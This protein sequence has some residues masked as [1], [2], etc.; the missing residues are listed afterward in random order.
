M[1]CIKTHKK[2]ENV[3]QKNEEFFESQP[4][5]FKP[6]MDHVRPFFEKQDEIAIGHL[7]AR[8]IATNLEP[9]VRIGYQIGHLDEFDPYKAIDPEAYSTTWGVNSPDSF[10]GELARLVD[11]LKVEWGKI[12]NF[13][14]WVV[15][16]GSNKVRNIFGDEINRQDEI[17][18]KEALS[19][20]LFD[21]KGTYIYRLRFYPTPEAV[22]NLVLM[23]GS[24]ENKGYQKIHAN[25]SLLFLKNKSNWPQVLDKAIEVYPNLKNL[26]LVLENW[27]DNEE[28]V[29]FYNI[30]PEIKSVISQ[31]ALSMYEG[32]KSEDKDDER[33]SNIKSRIR[34]LSL[35]CLDNEVLLNF[36][37][38][39]NLL[40]ESDVSV[41]QQAENILVEY[42]KDNTPEDI[43]KYRYISRF[44]RSLNRMLLGLATKTN[45]EFNDYK[46]S[47]KK[48]SEIIVENKNDLNAITYL[49]SEEIVDKLKKLDQK[50]IEFFLK[51]Y[52]QCPVLYSNKEFRKEFC[53]FFENTD[54]RLI[55]AFPQHATALMDEKMRETRSFI[56]KNGDLLLKNVSDI[57]FM[58]TFVGEF[59][60]K[61]DQLIRGY[62]DCLTEGSISNADKELVIEFARQF[63]V[64]SPII[65]KSYKEAKE[66]GH[67]KVYIAQLQSLAEKMTGS[68]LVTDEERKKQYYRELLKHVYP[69][70]SGKWTTYESNDSCKDR[71][72]DLTDF[73]IEPRYEIDL[74]SQNEIR[75][76][77]GETLDET[78]KE[79]LQEPILGVAKK[80]GVLGHDKEKIQ[81]VLQ[82]DINKKFQEIV[83]KNGL[84][85]LDSKSITKIEEKLFLIL[86]DSIYG[87][88]LVDRDEI[89]NLM[90]TYEFT[91][92]EDI[93][94]YIAGTSDRV[95]RANN[96]D[97]ALFC[98]LESF[99]S[100]RIKEV[101]RRL[102]QVAWDNPEIANI[103]PTFFKKL[104]QNTTIDQ[105]KDMINKLQIHRLGDSEDFVKKLGKTLEK[106]R[107]KKYATDEIRKI[108]ERYEGLTGG[109][110]EKA[111]SSPKSETRAFYGQLRSQR[112]RTFEA[113]KSITGQE[114]DPNETHLGEINF[115]QALDAE[116][117][118]KEGKYDEEQ[119]ASYTVQR[120]IDL[121]EDE[122]D[123]I[124]KELAKFESLSG[125]QRE[126]LYSYITKSNESA[127]ARMVG[128]VCVAGDN[129]GSY[130]KENMWDMPNYF[131]MVFQ[132]PETLQCQGLALLHY[133]K[134][135]DNKILTATFDPSSTYLYSVDEVAL[136][137]GI[138]KS[139]ERFAIEN[140][141]DMIVSSSDKTIRT[142][143]TG[144]EFE[145]AIE[146][147][148]A[149]IGQKFNFGTTRQFSYHPNY[150]VQEMDVIWKRN[151]T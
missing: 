150:Q 86:A 17:Y 142:N 30:N 144:G 95:G 124:D 132:E 60:N 98:E 41:F 125:K 71:N 34:E 104:A 11:D 87:N 136:F 37:K 65:I 55:L 43:E 105:R 5:I 148:V 39:K 68:G 72:S 126:V 103:M 111:S 84:Y 33:T 93:S 63:R 29:N 134:E 56:F 52:Q 36:L 64:I 20:S 6:L 16:R 46:N 35:N 12:D 102:I 145:K 79:N 119:F 94:D 32:S 89:K 90:I 112:E 10:T 75:V 115:Q 38:E 123:R 141:F 80:M 19:Y 53:Q 128:G 47:L 83:E 97:Y 57:K 108:I 15:L 14:F 140:D 133:F 138:I 21:E 74:L 31:F 23:A 147:R 70:N 18:Y 82:E 61:S 4:E 81:T 62:K 1:N 45:E 130:P 113:L 40:S 100:D 114:V 135:G 109:L 27:G 137:N 22:R 107:G 58:N 118:I 7:F 91:T 116:A 48:L 50:D 122:R 120:F 151:K 26:R 8:K 59:G 13:K 96:Q 110:T 66:A 146:K 28:W 44:K 121:F 2:E 127:H 69:N 99:Y 25:S 54:P 139:L 77:T 88:G 24:S 42:S 131:Q 85:G 49:A 101:N 129:P 3:Y 78:V 143:R 9:M 92:F 73:K 76:K 117:N 67:E 106:K 51:A 149:Q